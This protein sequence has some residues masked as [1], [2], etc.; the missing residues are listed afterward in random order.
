[1]SPAM[2]S[3]VLFDTQTLTQLIERCFDLSMDGDVP[4]AARADYL[5]QGKHLREQLIRLLGA[6]FDAATPEF[7]HASAALTET[8]QAL[9]TASENLAQVTRALARLKDLA[10]YLDKALGVAGKVIT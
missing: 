9:A 3:P 1:M 10:G 8:N 4:P 7:Q 6:R 5:A 2:P